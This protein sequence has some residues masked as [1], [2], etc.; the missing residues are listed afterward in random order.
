MNHKRRLLIPLV[1][2]G[3]VLT[4]SFGMTAKLDDSGARKTITLYQNGPSLVVMKESVKLVEGENSLR[5]SLPAT[6]VPET[7][8]TVSPDASLRTAKTIPVVNSQDQLLG[9]LVGTRVS[10]VKSGTPD[11]VI[12]GI[13]VGIFGGKPLLR[14]S[15]GLMRLISEP[16][17][18]RFQGFSPEGKNARLEL[19]LTAE[20]EVETELTVGYQLSKLNW[21]PQYVGFLDEEDESLILRGIAHINNQT[22]WDFRGAEVKL[23]A[24]E[25]SRE[26][27][28]ANFAEARSLSQQETPSPEQVFEYYRYELGFP[29]DLDSGVG[30]QVKFLH[31]D[32]V[33]YR[34]YYLF[35]PHSSS[36]VRTILELVNEEDEGLGLPLASGTVRIYEDT[37]DKTFVGEDTLP[38]LSVERE[39]ELE[40]GDAFDVKGD[41][42]RISHEKIDERVWKD[43]IKL[44]LDNKKEK[45]VQL[46][47]KERLSGDWEILRSS[48]DYERID[49]RLIQFDKTLPAKEMVEITYLVQYER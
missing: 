30:T 7:V 6:V 4:L 43:E 31:R 44:T 38:N 10:L 25:P 49:S 18:Y 9:E 41:R 48:H 1:V 22:G 11:T 17:E 14:T 5:R 45:P 2:I 33:D 42:K 13:L 47:V 27:Q 24:G 36:A 3:L 37:D 15:N 12:E 23:L 46:L 20:E 34:K 19:E 28:G 39:A 32:S 21:S 16:D 8:F 29:V 35:E 40:L 26:R